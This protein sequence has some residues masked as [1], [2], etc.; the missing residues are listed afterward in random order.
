VSDLAHPKRLAHTVYGN[1]SS[2][3][4]FDPHAFLWWAPTG[5]VVLPLQIFDPSGDLAQGFAGAVGLHVTA[6]A[7]AE[8]GR[9]AHGTSAQPAPIARSLVIGDRL[10]TLSSLGLQ[11]SRL[12][13]LAPI[14][15]VSFAP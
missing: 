3:A 12:D 14:A 8:Y 1:G 5:T 15:F 4:E 2:D 9:I 7:I 13:T 10:Y 6:Q 11:A